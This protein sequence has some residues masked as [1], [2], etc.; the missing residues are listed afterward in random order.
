MTTFQ[1]RAVTAIIFGVIMLVGLF[2]NDLSFETLFT[3]IALG[4]LW[5]FSLLT[6][7]E[8]A[9]F[10]TRVILYTVGTLF[11]FSLPIVNHFFFFTIGFCTTLSLVCNAFLMWLLFYHPEKKL[12]T[13]TIYFASLFYVIFPFFQIQ[14]L[15]DNLYNFPGYNP[16]LI[17]II[18]ILTW[19]NDT[20][21]YLIGSKVGKTPLYPKISPKKTWEGTIGGAIC[22]SLASALLSIFLIGKDHHGLGWFDYLVIGFMVGILGTIGDLVESMFKRNAKMKDSGSFMPGHGGFLDRFDAFIFVMPFI[23]FYIAFFRSAIA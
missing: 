10:R 15:A 23:F 12:S 8:T 3:V 19:A 14:A 20:F 18:L 22:C 2:W 1:Q 6:L 21:A 5:E 17:F 9:A 13:P 4:S 16:I 7:G 11:Y